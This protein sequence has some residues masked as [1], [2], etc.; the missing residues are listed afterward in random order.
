MLW[1]GIGLGIV[2]TTALI[3]K[4]IKTSKY[5]YFKIDLNCKNC[6]DRTNGLKCPK[7]ENRKIYKNSNSKFE[8]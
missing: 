4:Y 8:R 7:C 2:L 1:I 3:I 6:G 5:D